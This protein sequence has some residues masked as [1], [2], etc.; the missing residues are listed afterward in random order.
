MFGYGSGRLLRFNI[1]IYIYIYIFRQD[2]PNFEKDAC[3]Y[4]SSSIS[5]ICDTQ[6]EVFTAIIKI[7]GDLRVCRD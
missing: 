5:H 3:K 6:V 1:Y 4:L 7:W 2:Q